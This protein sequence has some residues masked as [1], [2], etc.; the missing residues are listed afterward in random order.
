MMQMHKLVRL[1]FWRPT[2]NGA[3][4]EREREKETEFLLFDSAVENKSHLAR[5]NFADWFAA[6]ASKKMRPMCIQ[7]ERDCAYRSAAEGKKAPLSQNI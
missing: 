2:Y 3:Y 4:K 6:K 5:R 7:L 1:Y